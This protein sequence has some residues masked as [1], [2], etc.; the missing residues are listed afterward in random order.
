MPTIF[1]CSPE[2]HER[3]LFVEWVESDIK[4]EAGH[5]DD[6]VGNFDNITLLLLDA[7]H[8]SED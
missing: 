7:R 3:N 1:W 8:A 2:S 4:G 5:K 6:K